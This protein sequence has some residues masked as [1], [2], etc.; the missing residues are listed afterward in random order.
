MYLAKQLFRISSPDSIGLARILEHLT[1]IL[2]ESRCELRGRSHGCK[3]GIGPPDNFGVI[4]PSEQS[5]D[6]EVDGPRTGQVEVEILGER[7][8]HRCLGQ[9]QAGVERAVRDNS[10]EGGNETAASVRHDPLE[11]GELGGHS[12]VEQVGERSSSVKR[13]IKCR[14]S[15]LPDSDRSVKSLPLLLRNSRCRLVDVE[16]QL[17]ELSARSC[18][19]FEDRHIKL[20]EGLVNRLKVTVAEVQ[21]VV[22]GHHD[23]S[24]GLRVELGEKTI[25]LFQRGLDVRERKRGEK[26]ELFG[27][28]GLEF[29]SICVDLAG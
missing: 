1:D 15:E 7:L 12:S 22:V 11:V 9:V 19:V 23:N 18:G 20:I 29:R 5:R 16:S 14:R 10:V 25:D 3:D 8:L 6:S 26:A 24:I 2:V 28:F 13:E 17:V 27:V 4:N 21:T